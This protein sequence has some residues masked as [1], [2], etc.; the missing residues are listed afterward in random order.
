MVYLKFVALALFGAAVT[1]KLIYVVVKM[2]RITVLKIDPPMAGFDSESATEI[3]VY[4]L[5]EVHEIPAQE[6]PVDPCLSIS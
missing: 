6:I 5:P 3:T 4:R 1:T 2:V